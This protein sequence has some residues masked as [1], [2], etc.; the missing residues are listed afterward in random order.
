M[1]FGFGPFELDDAGKTLCR[2][3]A[4]VSVGP[5]ALATLIHLARRSPEP[6]STDELLSALSDVQPVDE[7]R[8]SMAIGEL[9]GALGQV[10]GTEVVRDG[11]DD[12]WQLGL[13]VERLSEDLRDRRADSG[14]PRGSRRLAAILSTDA[15]GYSRLMAEDDRRTVSA[16]VAHREAMAVLVEAHGGRVV[17]A[18]GDNLLAEF[19]SG[20]ESVRCAL[21]IQEDIASR[22]R[23]V[24]EEARMRFRIGLHLGDVLADAGRLYGDTVNIA[25]RLEAQAPIGGLC[26]SGAIVE[27]AQRRLDVAFEDAG[28][29]ELKNIVRPVRAYRVRT[30]TEEAPGAPAARAAA[31]TP[32]AAA[33]PDAAPTPSAAATPDAPATAPPPAPEPGPR[34]PSERYV[35]RADLMRE[36]DSL[37]EATLAGRGAIALLSGEP[38]IGKT[39]TAEEISFRAASGGADVHWGRCVGGAGAPSLWPWS[40]ILRA[41]AGRRPA[42]EMR[43]LLG[44][45]A[46]TLSRVLPD[47]LPPADEARA[48]SRGDGGQEVDDGEERFRLFD[49]LTACLVRLSQE[50]PLVLVLD[51]LHWADESSLMLLEFLARAIDRSAILLLGTYRDVELHPA[52]SLERVLA[53]LAR[54]RSAR[55]LQ[56]DGL[57]LAEMAELVEDLAGR[58][59]SDELVRALR[60]RSEGNPFFAR[61]LLQLVGGEA[62]GERLPD[63]LPPGVAQV[64]QRRLADL[65]PSCRELLAT[66]AIIGREFR[67]P[68][69]ARA[70]ERPAEDVLAELEDAERTHL[71][72]LTGEGAGT[73]RFVHALIRET[74]EQ[75]LTSGRRARIHL[76][77]AEGLEEAYAAH[78]EPILSRLASHRAAALPLGDPGRALS[79]ALRAAHHCFHTLAF[80]DALG[81]CDLALRVID[82]SAGALEHERVETLELR[83]DAAFRAGRREEAALTRERLTAL[84]RERGDA[85]AFARAAIGL[86]SGQIFTAQSHEAIVRLIREAL[87]M[88][89][90]GD[91]ALR[92][93]LLSSLARQVTWTE[94]AQQRGGYSAEAVELARGS[95]DAATLLEVL[96]TRGTILELEGGDDERRRVYGEL[97]ALAQ[98]SGAQVYEADALTLRLEHRI[99]L[100]D[101]LGID[102]D[103]DELQEL[104][105]EVRHPI[106][107]AHAARARAM[108]ALW[109]GE[110]VEGEALVFEALR[111]GEQV[112]AEHAAVV[113]S[114]QLGLLRRLQGRFAE[115]ESALREAVERY[116]SMASFRCGLAAL[117]VETGRAD[118][119]RSILS[120]IAR[121]D[122]ADLRPGDPNTP[123][124]LALLAEVCADARAVEHAEALSRRLEPFAGRYVTVPNVLA[125]GC[126]SRYLARLEGVRDRHDRACALLDDAIEVERRLGAHAWLA[127]SLL[128]SAR[129]LHARAGQDDA[130]AARARAQECVGL[131]RP[132]GL[133][134]ALA[135]AE[136][137]LATLDG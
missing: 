83:G 42:A 74:L 87:R 17:D 31:A 133:G 115:L 30:G 93:R 102:A 61:E 116:A 108:R 45:E 1:R 106:Y 10:D 85:A 107:V 66:A 49:A 8:L 131:A 126:G 101:P 20:V 32:T 129:A 117:C 128:D 7:R 21:A 105:E 104:A 125:G 120:D 37:V 86:A 50:R 95:G 19:P 51:D 23:S 53:S 46:E 44:R 63:A 89:G 81:L 55:T 134:A 25:A 91:K 67:V 110:L 82:E 11:P 59:A 33:T 29:L 4:L 65:S 15:V 14:A 111:A 78:P 26:V 124:N 127:H 96:A 57:E 73:H 56:L 13:S 12:R 9:L 27:Q 62:D 103:L 38:G 99:E 70:C 118:E 132:R 109:R 35:G 97:L 39:R 52:P 54:A 24:P 130:A 90:Q 48:R 80:E 112:D 47:V 3:G 136:S 68:I 71:V 28:E 72:E 113:L 79:D 119:A 40:E 69:L 64:V 75:E 22:N 76:R 2:S 114:A 58:S 123:V 36:L 18:V 41:I 16:L 5:L 121:R 137:L 100:A 135:G 94:E 92:A 43:A 6:C 34:R 122:F 84:A 77:V 88:L 98:S 60:D